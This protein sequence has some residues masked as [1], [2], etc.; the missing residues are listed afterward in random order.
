MLRYAVVMIHSETL[1][2]GG[3]HY[4]DTHTQKNAQAQTYMF[5]MQTTPGNTCTCARDALLGSFRCRAAPRGAA[6]A[7]RG[8]CRGIRAQPFIMTHDIMTGQLLF[9]FGTRSERQAPD[10]IT[11]AHF[12]KRKKKE[13]NEFD[14]QR[15]RSPESFPPHSQQMP[16]ALPF[17]RRRHG[18]RGFVFK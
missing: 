18:N 8:E 15:C 11:R 1:L 13:K 7:I 9:C 17:W 14:F 2:D 16:P 5:G 6:A 10:V 12:C 4:K 3:P